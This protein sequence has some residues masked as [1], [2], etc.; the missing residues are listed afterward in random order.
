MAILKVANNAKSTLAVELSSSA[1][2]LTIQSD[3]ASLFPAL[4]AGEWFPLTLIQPTGGREIVRATAR[5]GAAITIVRAQEGTTAKVFPVGSAVDLRLTSG[6]IAEF[7]LSDVLAAA[8]AGKAAASHPHPFSDLPASPTLRIA[9]R[10]SSGS[11]PLE[12]LTAA[13][14]KTLL[15]IAIA[16]VAGLTDALAGKSATGHNHAV[17]DIQNVTAA[18]FLGRAEGNG[19]A[20]QLTAAQVKGLLAIGLGDLTAIA[21][22]RIVGRIAAGAGTPQELT[23]AQVKNFLSIA[24]ADVAD[25][26]AALAAKSNTDHTHAL[27]SLS[28]IQTARIVGR[29]TAG[30]G[31]PEI[32]TVAEAKT[33]LAIAIADVAG[34]TAAL[35][36]KQDSHSRFDS[37]LALGANTGLFGISGGAFTSA[38]VTAGTGISVTGGSG[39]TPTIAASIASQAQA[40]AGSV[41]DQMM[42]PLRVAQAI[43]AQATVP[44]TAAGVNATDFPI[45]TYVAFASQGAPARNASVAIR[46]LTGF[47]T[48]YTTEGA[49]S[50]LAGTWRSSGTSEIPAASSHYLARRVA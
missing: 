50:L 36:G 45:G 28:N 46:L 43:A 16:D 39:L 37:L 47:N 9:G 40:Q 6:A 10:A 7:V 34:L 22:A 29:T 5:T 8:L 44:N 20:E 32:L 26:V 33:L 42:T 31:P 17:G 30:N 15:A 11:G 27:T 12:L 38:T 21:T 41:N 25:L 19:S 35:G 4:A 2:S 1:T 49:G 48:G 23:A 3:D 13:Q 24:I 18:R 14:V